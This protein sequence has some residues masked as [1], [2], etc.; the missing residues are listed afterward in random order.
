[1]DSAIGP[2]NLS[3]PAGALFSIAPPMD[4]LDVIGMIVPPAPSHAPRAYVVRNDV[5]IVR[6]LPLAEGARPVLGDDLSVHQL[7][8][9]R[10]G[11]DLPISARMLG[12]V[13]AT[14]S[15]LA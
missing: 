1:M 14:D 11:A 12:I 2:V 7:S 6:E 13:D 3:R 9:F 15:H 4:R 8:H 10:I 5:A